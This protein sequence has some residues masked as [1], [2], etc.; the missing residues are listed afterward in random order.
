MSWRHLA[1]GTQ[2]KWNRKDGNI[3]ASSHSE[4][5][6]I[7][8]RRVS[9]SSDYPVQH[10]LIALCDI[11]KGSLPVCRIKAHNSKIYG[12]DWSHDVRN[13]IVT[14]SLDKTIK[15]WDLDTAS[16][17]DTEIM[18]EPKTIMRTTYPVW[19]ARNLPFGRGV[20]SLAQRGMTTLEMYAQSKPQEPAEIFEGHTDVVKEFVW[21]KGGS[22]VLF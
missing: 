20:L 3:F 18:C 2:V 14:C 9:H 1:G 17:A 10:H 11:Q 15:V 19:R 22:G 12:I 4:E 16:A 6:F 13:E 21:R 5:V 8:D 7:W